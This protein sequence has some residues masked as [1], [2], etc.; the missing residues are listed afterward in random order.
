MKNIKE[1]PFYYYIKSI[2]VLMSNR[3]QAAS[4]YFIKFYNIVLIFTLSPGNISYDYN[5]IRNDPTI[6]IWLL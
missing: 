6:S 5:S 2:N 4:T 1:K 3:L